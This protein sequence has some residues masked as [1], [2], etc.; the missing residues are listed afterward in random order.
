MSTFGSDQ[1]PAGVRSLRSDCASGQRR[2]ST[3]PATR[4]TAASVSAVWTSAKPVKS[5]QARL[6]TA[7]PP[8]MTSWNAARVRARTQPGATR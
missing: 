5:P 4:P 1:T 2:A 8:C 6:P 3:T 7:S